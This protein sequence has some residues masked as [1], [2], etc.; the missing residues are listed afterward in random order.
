M[1]S[2]FY[3]A[4]GIKHV[5]S[6]TDNIF[7]IS[8][9]TKSYVIRKYLQGTCRQKLPKISSLFSFCNKIYTPGCKAIKVCK[10]Y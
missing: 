5:C 9:D 3:S 8:F 7:H 6:T 10:Y 1:H 2:Q 4:A